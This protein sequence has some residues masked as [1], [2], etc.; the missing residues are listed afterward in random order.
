MCDNSATA[1]VTALLPEMSGEGEDEIDEIKTYMVDALLVAAADSEQNDIDNADDFKEAAEGFLPA[2]CIDSEAVISS[3][4]VLRSQLKQ[5][6]SDE[7]AEAEAETRSPTTLQTLAVAVT[8]DD[9]SDSTAEIA[10]AVASADVN[11][12][13]SF[14][15]ES[16]PLVK[17]AD[18]K[19]LLKQVRHSN[20]PCYVVSVACLKICGTTCPAWRKDQRPC[21]GPSGAAAAECRKTTAA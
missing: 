16:F 7:I 20:L 2:A 13:M 11:V 14:C 3:I 17:P 8:G 15:I 18:V 12:D 6:N 4:R 19:S 5:A 10:P 1:L 21:A 9:A